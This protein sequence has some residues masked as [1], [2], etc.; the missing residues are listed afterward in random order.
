MVGLQG[1]NLSSLRLLER[2]WKGSKNSRCKQWHCTVRATYTTCVVATRHKIIPKTISNHCHL[3]R[4]PLLPPAALF[5]ARR[6]H[7]SHHPRLRIT[8]HRASSHVSS[9]AFTHIACRS[10]RPMVTRYRHITLRRLP[11]APC[12]CIT[13]C[14]LPLPEGVSLCFSMIFIFLCH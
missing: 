3:H 12:R 1:T 4:L 6:I 7:Q 2:R 5:I 13:L 8:S 11:L 9:S 14:R 10:M